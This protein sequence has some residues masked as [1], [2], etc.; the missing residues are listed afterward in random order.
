MAVVILPHQVSATTK[1]KYV[2]LDLNRGYITTKRPSGL[3]KAKKVSVKSSK[4]SVATVG[5]SKKKGDRRVNIVGKKVGKTTITVKCQ[6]KNR[7]T[8]TYKYKVT[9][10][11]KHVKTALEKGK[12]AF[13]MQNQ[14]RKEAGVSTLQWSDELYQFC[15]YR[16]KTSGYD[17][18]ANLGKDMNSY[19]GNFAGFKSLLFGENMTCDTSAKEAMKSWKN[20]LGHYRN[21]LAS[22]HICG[23][24][25]TYKGMWFA[26][27]YDKDSSELK[28]WKSYHIK[29]IVVK[30]YNTT[31]GAAIAGSS[32]GYYENDNRSGSLKTDRISKAEGKSIYLEIGKTYVIY[33][34]I[35]PSGYEK[36][37]SVTITVTEDGAS[38]V[39]LT[40]EPS[41]N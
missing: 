6:Y 3:T 19:F 30:R 38:E 27:F 1:T 26:V 31:T 20:S 12:E 34:T 22:S 24:I 11:K 33:E 40:S 15:L 28:N 18:H 5:Y 17:K 4:K 16:M 13:Q 9:V 29:E 10:V 23:A 36:A 37:K 25:A 35:R 7:R 8:T 14:L 2:T 32:I 21:L 41:T 39:V